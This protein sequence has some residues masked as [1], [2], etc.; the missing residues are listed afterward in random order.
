MHHLLLGY[1]LFI[2]ALDYQYLILILLIYGWR[3]YR[4]SKP[5]AVLLCCLMLMTTLRLVTWQPQIE[6]QSFYDGVITRVDTHS[7]RYV[8]KTDQG[9]VYVYVDQTKA[10][11]G[12]VLR[13]QGDLRK[14]EQPTFPL[15]FNYPNYLRAINIKGIIIATEVEWMSHQITIHHLRRLVENYI[16]THFNESVPYLKTFILADR[17]D[18]DPGLNQNIAQL[19]IAHLFAVSGM[20]ITLMS[21]ILVFGLKKIT[22]KQGLID[23][24]L[25]LFLVTYV[26]LAGFAPSVLRASFMAIGIMINRR[27]KL[28]FSAF[29][30]LAILWIAVLLKN[31][32]AMAQIGLLL[33]F[34]VTATL[35]LLH[36]KFSNHNKLIQMG[37]V[38]SSA[39]LVT[40]PII[41]T[42][43]LSINLLTVVWNIVFIYYVM[44][45]ILP[46]TYIT[47]LI[48]W[49]ES[50]L[51]ITIQVFERLVYFLSRMDFLTFRWIVNPGVQ[52]IIYYGLLLVM[53]QS[54]QWTQGIKRLAVLLLFLIMISNQAWFDPTT[55]LIMYD[56]RGDAFLI[57]DRF[58]Q[59][60]I[61]IDTGDLDHHKNLVHS[62]IKTHVTHIDYLII[63]HQ[64]RDHYGEYTSVIENLPVYQVITNDN[65]KDFQGNPHHCGNLTFYIYPAIK[66]TTNENDNSLVMRVYFLDESI[67]FTGD[68]EAVTEH[69]YATHYDIKASI[70]K[71]AH[72]GSITSTTELFLAAVNPEQALVPA[73]RKNTFNHPSKTVIKRLEEN[74][75]EIHRVDLEGTVHFRYF[76]HQRWKKN[77]QP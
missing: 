2:F 64:H 22:Q 48:P 68:I 56:V 35:L 1:L 45:I 60:N 14:S 76:L 63:S 39:F 7:N 17:S 71:V 23:I 77:Y 31:P 75:I 36:P 19:G 66:K 33:T 44:F 32:Y 42:M 61:L 54:K 4:Y 16:N 29:D 57:R 58:N 6:V 74:H 67:L 12:D 18:I 20:H 51:M 11:V 21:L 50:L 37:I 13:V 40:L 59:C 53:F 24:A 62:L 47:F 9:K 70:L 65:Q 25:T 52:T 46:L 28:A 72:H 5:L 43:Q 27:F 10:Q 41:A 8:L 30:L 69:Y 26:I 55:Q 49:F 38:S 73:H 15:G 3:L 34:L